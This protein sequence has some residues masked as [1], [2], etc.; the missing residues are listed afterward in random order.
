V[1]FSI[2]L[3][4]V[5]SVFSPL[6]YSGDLMRGVIRAA[7]IGYD[8]VELNIRDVTSEKLDDFVSI[9]KSY[10]LSIVA[11]G[12]GQSYLTD[13]WSILS[14]D[15]SIRNKLFNRLKSHTDFCS[16]TGAKL[17]L[18][19]VFG[20]LE[21]NDEEKEK[22]KENAAEFVG[23]LA[24]YASKNGVDLLLEPINRYETNFLNTIDQALQFIKI[25]DCLNVYVL[26]DT[27]HMNI[28]EEDPSSAIKKAGE[29]IK[30][31]HVA[32]SN[33]FAAG[34]GHID[35]RE[36][37]KALE[38]IKYDGFAS[39]EFVPLPDDDTAASNHLLYLKKVYTLSQP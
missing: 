16:K 7:E 4:P 27:F 28:E 18:G 37:L 32:D 21:G 15:S 11:L 39:G 2:A 13:G 20:K 29:K 12:T 24:R 17:I 6:L 30:H 36:V 23:E 26:P 38:S 8:G 19:G 22:Q 34:S 14:K 10:H 1:K 31:F 9:T 35:F 3:S 25:L 5:K 33:R